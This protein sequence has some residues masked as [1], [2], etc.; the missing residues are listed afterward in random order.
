MWMSDTWSIV[1]VKMFDGINHQLVDMY[2]QLD[3]RRLSTGELMFRG[4]IGG[5]VNNAL[6]IGTDPSGKIPDITMPCMTLH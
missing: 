1:N 5:S 6:H 3:V 2:L 4:P